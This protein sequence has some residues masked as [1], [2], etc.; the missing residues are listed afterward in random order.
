MEYIKS[1]GLSLLAALG[2]TQPVAIESTVLEPLKIGTTRI[3]IVQGDITKQNVDAIVNA[4][5]EELKHGGG[6][7]KAIAIA[8]GPEFQ[9]DSDAMPMMVN[10]EKCPMGKAVITPAFN[11]EKVGIKKVIHTTGP[12]GITLDKEQLLEDAYQN[13]LKVAQD[14]NL[15]SIAFPAI[16]T[17]IFGYDINKATPIAF[18]AVKD[19]LIQNPDVFDEVRFVVFSDKDLAVYNSNAAIFRFQK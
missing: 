2:F 9:K 16:S 4:A 18:R 17:A 14:N 19:F 1:W 5:N 6:V 7:A 10:G 15:K 3:T 13:S 8:A 11:L 12:R